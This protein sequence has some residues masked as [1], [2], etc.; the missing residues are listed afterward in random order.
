MSLIFHVNIA[1]ISQYIEDFVDSA[2][3]VAQALPERP[4]VISER[5]LGQAARTA[6]S[7]ARAA[8]KPA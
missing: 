8:R 4:D 6:V 3:L 1:H 7:S 2:D 5:A